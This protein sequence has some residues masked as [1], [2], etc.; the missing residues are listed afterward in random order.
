MIRRVLA[1]VACA[2]TA[3]GIAATP[4]PERAPASPSPHQVAASSVADDLDRIFAD[5]VLARALTG[6]RVESLA[7]R[8]LLYA[9]NSEKLRR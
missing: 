3:A 1:T 7:S 6:I 5:P 4:A 2:W 9:R 8:R